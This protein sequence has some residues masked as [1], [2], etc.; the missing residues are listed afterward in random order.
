[1]KP[2]LRYHE[3]SKVVEQASQTTSSIYLEQGDAAL[4]EDLIEGYVQNFGRGKVTRVPISTL[5]QLMR[6]VQYVPPDRSYRALVV[7]NAHKMFTPRSRE[8]LLWVL[9]HNKRNARL[10][11]VLVGEE[12]DEETLEWFMEERAYGIVGEPTFEKQGAWMATKTAGRWDYRST[13]GALI[14]EADGLKL[15][16]HV[17]WDYAAALQAAATIRVY[18]T[19]VLSW[20]TVA[21]LIPP[22]VGFGYADSIV[23]GKG[24]RSALRLSEGVPEH[25]VMRTLGLVRY[26]LRQFAKLRAVEVD[27]MSDRAVNAET[28][29]HVWHWRTKYKPVYPRYT[30]DRIRMRQGYVEDAMR[31]ARMGSVTGVLEVLALE[32]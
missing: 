4:T 27:K 12:P 19:E 11:V 15:L 25:E 30:N 2:A 23:F 1:M 16:E 32:W 3:L 28:G 6:E 10:R 17:G 26:Y 18:A 22:K 21:A 20:A 14:T 8:S 7:R 29:M 5:G 13:D 31:A 24:L 9:D